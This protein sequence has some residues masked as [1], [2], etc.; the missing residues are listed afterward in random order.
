MKWNFIGNDNRTIT[1]ENKTRRTN[2]NAKI[3]KTC[4]SS[5][6]RNSIYR[7]QESKHSIIEKEIITK[8][9]NKSSRSKVCTKSIIFVPYST[10]GSLGNW[11]NIKLEISTQATN[12]KKIYV[13]KV[14]DTAQP[15]IRRTQ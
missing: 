11:E 15:H 12:K 1:G 2:F 6:R 10:T 3:N 5:N 7:T 13:N 9:E 8:C 14:G 4:E